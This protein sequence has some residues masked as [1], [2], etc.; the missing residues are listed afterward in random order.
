MGHTEEAIGDRIL[1]GKDIGQ[2][3]ANSHFEQLDSQVERSVSAE[4]EAAMAAGGLQVPL[5]GAKAD[6]QIHRCDVVG[7][8]GKGEGSYRATRH[9]MF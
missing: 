2:H 1:S 6:G 5:G 7:E 3:S 4:F 8:D 9:Q